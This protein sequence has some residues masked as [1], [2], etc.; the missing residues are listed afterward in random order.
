MYA[1]LSVPP[2]IPVTTPILL[3][4]VILLLVDDH[5]PFD[6]DAFNVIVLP[7][8]KVPEPVIAPA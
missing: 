1:I 5:I 2:L 7:L 8:H 3:T 6:T 4:V